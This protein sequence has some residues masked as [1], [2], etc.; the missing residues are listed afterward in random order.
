MNI[1]YKAY[2]DLIQNNEVVFKQKI[3]IMKNIYNNLSQSQIKQTIDETIKK[4]NKLKS[5]KTDI[6]KKKETIEKK[7]ISIKEKIGKY[8]LNDD[9][10]NNYLKILGDYQRTVGDKLNSV[11][12]KIV[13]LENN[14]DK[15]FSFTNLFPNFDLDF[16]LI[17]KDNQEKY[18]EFEKKVLNNSKNIKQALK[19]I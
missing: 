1:I 17:E 12:R 13:F 2:K 3:N 7:I 15:I 14:I 5:T 4:I 8:E 10:I 16:N 6:L 11:E 9:E 19:N 18:L